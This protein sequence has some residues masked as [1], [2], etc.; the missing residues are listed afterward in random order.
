MDM[1][2]TTLELLEDSLII[3]YCFALMFAVYKFKE[4]NSSVICV[5]ILFCMECIAGFI[6]EPL[7]SLNSWEVWYGAWILYDCLLVFFLYKTHKLLKVNLAKIINLVALS[8]VI[9]AWIHAFRYI[10]RTFLDGQHLDTWYV[11]AISSINTT[12]AIIVIFTLLKDKEEK[13]VGIYI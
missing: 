13:R 7:L 5:A 12:I 8:H 11:V 2:Y 10:E 6:D 3:I 1:L 4:V 9:K